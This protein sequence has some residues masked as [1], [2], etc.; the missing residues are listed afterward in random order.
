MMSKRPNKPVELHV[1][2]YDVEDGNEVKK[3]T[4]HKTEAAAHEYL[5]DILRRA[6]ESYSRYEIHFLTAPPAPGSAK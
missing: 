4:V 2:R 1:F 3:V 6:D 5:A